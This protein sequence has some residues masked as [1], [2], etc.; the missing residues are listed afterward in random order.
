M[1]QIEQLI[2]G[3]HQALTASNYQLNPFAIP[4]FIVPVVSMALS[5]MIFKREGLNRTSYSFR[6]VGISV[7]VWLWSF[8]MMYCSKGADAAFFWAKVS[9]LGIPMIPAALYQFTVSVLDIHKEKENKRN[10]RLAWALSA[11]FSMLIIG[12]GYVIRGMRLYWW[13]Y[14]PQYRWQGS[15]YLLYFGGFLILSLRHFIAQYRKSSP[16]SVQRFRIKALLV[17]FTVSYLGLFDYLAKF[18]IPVYPFGYLPVMMFLLLIARAMMR[19]RLID[20]TPQ[21]AA[22]SIIDTIEDALFVLDS[23]GFIR[24]VNCA[25]TNLFGIAGECLAGRHASSIIK[26][27][28]FSGRAQKLMEGAVRRF[29]FPYRQEQKDTDRMLSLSASIMRDGAGR[30]LAAVC[31]VRDITERKQA[32]AEL[33]QAREEL[34]QRV[35]QRTADLKAANE[36]LTQEMDRRA[37]MEIE[38]LKMQK[39]ESIGLLAGGIA[40]DFNNILTGVTGKINLARPCIEP[41][42]KAAKLLNDAERAL[43]RARDLTQ[44]LLTFSKGGNPV[45]KPCSISGTVRDCCEFSLSGSKADF[46]FSAEP[47]LWPALVDDGQIS[48]VINNLAINASQAMPA[49]GTVTVDC[50]NRNIDKDSGLPLEQGKYVEISVKDT[51]DGIPEKNMSMIFDPFFTTKERGTGLGLTTSYSIVKKHGGHITVNSSPGRGTTFNIYLPACRAENLP[52]PDEKDQPPASRGSARILVMDDDD[53]I[54]DICCD[55]L[56]AFGYEVECVKDG[57]EALERYRS[58]KEAGRAFDLVIMDLTVPGGLGGKE[59]LKEIMAFD[60]FVKA[61]VSSGYSSDPVM[62]D[63]RDYGFRGVI[64]K[65]FKITEL[66]SVL[67]RVLSEKEKENTGQIF[68]ATAGKTEG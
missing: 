4:L 26:D 59:T 30:P 45:K 68:R 2:H 36:Q 51:G 9:Y 19:Y 47:G 38:L 67:N 53:M 50:R 54:R 52:G 33:K 48:Q 41:G 16:G 21:F 31:I 13:G 60:P 43:L 39:L 11:L 46:L 5:C 58:A 57:K 23:E 14:Y 49:G 22:N 28:I 17:A 10:I 7:S 40:H 35:E 61:V 63:F 34:E 29:E 37:K 20:I 44:R 18:G 42:N 8:S 12:T 1:T 24:L 62:S 15:I 25:A 27:D 55:A 56:S 66:S 64:A 6:M 65:P 32:E 3:F